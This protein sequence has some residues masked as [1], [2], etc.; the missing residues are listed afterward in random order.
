MPPRRR[1]KD[2]NRDIWFEP[3]RGPL[4][5]AGIALVSHVRQSVEAAEGRR[6]ARRAAD[7]VRFEAAVTALVSDLA[8][9]FLA[10][11]EERIVVSRSKRILGK[12]SRYRPSF[13][14][15]AFPAL[16]DRM[17]SPEL[18]WVDQDV[19]QQGDER[20][21]YKATSIYAGDALQTVAMR[22]GLAKAD[23]GLL[24]GAIPETIILKGAAPGYWEAA[25]P[26]EYDDTP[27]TNA[28]REEM[29]RI[30]AAIGNMDIGV[31]WPAGEKGA[32]NTARRFLRR[33]FNNGTFDNGGRLF[34]GFWMEMKADHRLERMTIN[35][36][37]V[38]SI[39]FGQLGPRVLYGMAG[40]AP[41]EGDL[42]AVP[43]L[44]GHRPGV[45]RLFNAMIFA[46]KPLLR[47]PK[48]TADLL[49]NM[50][51]PELEGRIGAAHPALVPLFGRGVGH[52]VHRVES[53]ILIRVL[54][55]LETQGI[56]A[57]PIHDAILLPRQYVAEGE[58]TMLQAFRERAGAE[59]VVSVSLPGEG[60]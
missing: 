27:E 40:Q 2:D 53:D 22:E 25:P 58:R 55:S 24:P 30:N 9:H 32:P 46:T 44:E 20:N 36:S 57:L 7:Q 43:G 13:L 37:P 39:D 59:G 45:K 52:R 15:E 10:G 26:R 16:L 56:P 38:A 4:T 12:R 50:S 47:K 17:A 42:Y 49:P 1:P 51:L 48:E 29:G 8:F 3:L 28:M 35:G 54:L 41:P 5:A 60:T 11:T 31:D 19:G 21:G 6:R 33:T 14:G 23:F 18:A 34:G